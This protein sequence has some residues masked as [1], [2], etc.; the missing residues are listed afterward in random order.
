MPALYSVKISKFA[1]FVPENAVSP[2]LLIEFKIQ[3]SFSSSKSLK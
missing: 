1:T 3:L 2:I